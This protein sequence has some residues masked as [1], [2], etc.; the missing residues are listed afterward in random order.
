MGKGDTAVANP[1]VSRS[2]SSELEWLLSYP[3]Q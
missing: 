3:P 2:A 1:H